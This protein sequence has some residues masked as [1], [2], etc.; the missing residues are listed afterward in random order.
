MHRPDHEDTAARMTVVARGWEEW[1][2]ESC[3]Q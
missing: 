2:M 3:V 1:G